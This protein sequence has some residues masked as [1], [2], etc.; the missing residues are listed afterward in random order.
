[1][2]NLN[3]LLIDDELELV[4]TLVERLEIRGIQAEAASN[5][6]DALER[7]RQGHFDVVVADLKM[8]IMSGIEVMQTLRE[9]FPDIKVV[10]IT[11]HGS[12]DDSSQQMVERA[13]GLLLKPFSIDSLIEKVNEVVHLG[14]MPHE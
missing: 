3:L 6:R 10:L 5:G 7:V 8:P 9:E 14:D 4:T 1:M 11:G 12:S 13:D 2:K